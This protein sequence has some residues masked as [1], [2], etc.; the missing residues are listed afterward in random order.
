MIRR[1]PRS[2]LFPYTTLFRSP[3]LGRW[4]RD[5]E[6]VPGASRVAVLAHGLWT[7]RYGRDPGILGRPVM[8]AGVPMEVIGVM[9]ASYAFPDARV[10]VWIAEPITRSMGFGIWAFQGVGRVRDGVVVADARAELNGL[11]GDL[12]RAYPGD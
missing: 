3:A 5:E 4:F 12:S 7:R 8:L 2:T 6:G 1:P 11:I 9:P 10:D